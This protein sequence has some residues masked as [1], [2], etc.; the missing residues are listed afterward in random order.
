VLE[1][2]EYHPDQPDGPGGGDGHVPGHP[3]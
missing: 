1:W 3:G 2:V